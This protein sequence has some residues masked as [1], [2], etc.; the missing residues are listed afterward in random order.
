MHTESEDFLA[1]LRATVDAFIDRAKQELELRWKAWPIDLSR[2][3]LHEVIGALTA[4]QVTLATQLA[5]NISIWNDH[6][7]PIVLRTMADTYIT[8]VWI[9]CDPITR[10]KKFIEYGLGQLKL[11]IEHRKADM[12]GR[13]PIEGE[14]E[15]IEATEQWINEQR[16][17]FLTEIDLGNW[18]GTTT[19]QMAE[20]AGCLDF[21]NYVYTPFSACTHSM[22]H[23]IA[24]FNLVRCVNPLHRFHRVPV[25]IDDSPP[26]CKCCIWPESIW[27][28]RLQRSINKPAPAFQGP[29]H[30][31]CCVRA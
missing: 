12:S 17:I 24:R 9:L 2:S 8:L 4:R 15:R 5:G 22:W 11:Q 28:K 18:S 27:R 14:Q 31:S 13:Q 21:Y 30:L 26:I 3:D 16:L 29:R 7:A 6:L 10:P 19:R 20:E 1:A 23:H 25:A